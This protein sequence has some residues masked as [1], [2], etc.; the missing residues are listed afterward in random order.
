MRHDSV[1]IRGY[2]SS[3][4]VMRGLIGGYTGP[5]EA[6]SFPIG[7]YA[8]HDEV[9]ISLIIISFLIGVTKFGPTMHV[10]LLMNRFVR[11]TKE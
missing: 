3:D 2:T 6:K 9:M 8:P 1:P 4:E 5:D 7:G 10:S 11:L